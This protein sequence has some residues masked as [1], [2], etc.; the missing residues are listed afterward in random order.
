MSYTGLFNARV[1]ASSN[2]RLLANNRELVDARTRALHKPVYDIVTEFG[3]AASRTGYSAYLIVRN[4]VR[5]MIKFTVGENPNIAGV[6][7]ILTGVS[8]LAGD[9]NAEFI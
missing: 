5:A 8:V 4:G 3:W 9:P 2:S 1:R 7:G 6:V